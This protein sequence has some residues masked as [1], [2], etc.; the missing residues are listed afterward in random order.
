MENVELVK[1]RPAGIV[2]GHGRN[3]G[4]INKT[5]K[6][7]TDALRKKLDE[8]HVLFKMVDRLIERLENDEIKTSDLINGFKA[9]AP[10]IVQTVNM[11][12][13]AEQIAAIS[14]RDDAERV[15]AEITNQLRLVR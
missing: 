6:E 2:P 12:Q 10:Y 11:D 14:N 13:I 9:I 1:S 8:S 15:A 4:S 7:R 5:T 3:K